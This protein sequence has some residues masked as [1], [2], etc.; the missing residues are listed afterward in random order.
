VTRSKA[1]PKRKKRQ[2]TA[3]SFRPGPDPR[4]H[5]FT[6]A[7]CRLG[8]AHAML[9]KGKCND[10]KVCAYVWRKVRKYYS[11]RERSDDGEEDEAGSGTAPGQQRNGA[12]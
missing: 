5:V 8:Y 6:R 1:G 12:D 4:R 11:D 3:G 2:A 9:G 10:P 7:E